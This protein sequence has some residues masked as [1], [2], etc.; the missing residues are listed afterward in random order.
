MYDISNSDDVSS[1]I[2]KSSLRGDIY[3]F[4]ELMNCINKSITSG[5]K[6]EMRFDTDEGLLVKTGN[7]IEATYGKTQK[8]DLEIHIK[9]ESETLLYNF[10]ML[11]NMVE[12]NEYSD[13]ITFHKTYITKKNSHEVIVGFI[14]Y[15][16]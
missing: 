15:L 10:S 11:Q 12:M 3:D 7:I 5:L 8:D 16:K 13:N 2:S 1:L 6:V 4:I 9:T 14:F